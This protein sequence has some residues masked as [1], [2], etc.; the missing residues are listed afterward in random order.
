M[1]ALDAGRVTHAAAAM[2]AHLHEG[3]ACP[4]CL[5][6][7]ESL[8]A[9]PVTA[10][11][12]ALVQAADVATEREKAAGRAHQQTVTT[13][14]QATALMSA[15][16]DTL[17]SV[18][19]KHA[20]RAAARDAL[21]ATIAAAVPDTVG[22]ATTRSRR[23]RTGT[24]LADSAAAVLDQVEQRLGDLRLAKAERDRRSAAVQAAAA[25]LAE[26]TLALAHAESG[27]RAVEASSEQL[28]AEQTRLQRQLDAVIAHIRAVTT[29]DDPKAERA[30]LARQLVEWRDAEG[31]AREA[32]TA[33]D[34]AV[35]AATE[36]LRAADE[37]SSNCEVALISSRAQLAAAL[38]AAMFVDAEDLARALRTPA[39]QAALQKTVSAHDE[40]RALVGHQ[41]A[42]LEPKVTGREVS[43][44]TLA[45][46][47]R[48]RAETQTRWQL[49]NQ[50]VATLQSEEGR[51]RKDLAARLALVSERE[52]LGATLEITTEMANDLKSDGFQDY[53]LEEAFLSLVGGAS[54][55][56]REI[57]NRY[58]LD[59]C[60]SEFHVIDHDNAGERRRADTLSG[61]E[62]FMASL[63]LAL[64]LSET[65]LQASGALQM[66]SLFVDEGFGTLDSDAL[67]EVTDAIERLG[68][69]GQRMVGVISHREEL[70]DRLPGLIRIE[71]GM[72]ESTWRVERVG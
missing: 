38:A 40:Q 10:A 44:E 39:A 49:V 16:A 37:A 72:G 53:L 47:V 68:R 23:A 26:A 45:T 29:A 22:A 59:W 18:S 55:R 24:A 5:Q 28:R 11:L 41:L 63:C 4:V 6:T 14:A 35:T 25:E 9:V 3:E 2:R 1:R 65:V 30:A 32:L 13:A 33:A 54:V 69:D 51:L 52:A 66:D 34:L 64:Q 43:S 20:H 7:V 36:R 21:V 19:A 60:D 31:R 12:A 56:M 46:A 58:T 27:A 62:T 17:T 15:A 57:S 48:H 70:T 50:Q 67:A 61:G 71:K 42:A 8:P